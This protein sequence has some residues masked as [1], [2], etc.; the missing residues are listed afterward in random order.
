[1]EIKN[2]DLVKESLTK[3]LKAHSF[4]VKTNNEGQNKLIKNCEFLFRRLEENGVDRAVSTTL[5]IYGKEFLEFEI[6][7]LLEEDE[8]LFR[9]ACE[10]FG[11]DQSQ[12]NVVKKRTP[13]VL[14]SPA[15]PA[16][17]SPAPVQQTF[18]GA[19]DD[20]PF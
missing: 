12:M 16:S 2:R 1:M 9:L 13:E 7:E 3:L 17:P 18:G 10:I 20:I 8:K 15:V 19:D 14:A 4:F 11:V 5:L 6:K